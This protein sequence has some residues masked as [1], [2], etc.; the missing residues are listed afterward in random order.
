[1]ITTHAAHVSIDVAAPAAQVWKGLT[2]PEIVAQ[3]MYG[4]EVISDWTVGGPLVY[5]GEWEGVPYEDKGTILAIEPPRLLR[6][7]YFSPSS[8]LPDLPENYST[9]TYE[10]SEAGGRTTLAVTQDG[11]ASPEDAAKSEANWS[12]ALAGLKE[13]VENLPAT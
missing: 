7:T 6:T 13:A 5:R 4:A 12:E 11:S 2:T 10:L 3:Y 9:V 8:G 1:M